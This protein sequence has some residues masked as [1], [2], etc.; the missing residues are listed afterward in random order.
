MLEVA[1]LR[2]ATEPMD[3]GTVDRMVESAVD[4]GAATPA[5]QEVVND[6]KNAGPQSQFFNATVLNF[7]RRGLKIGA[8]SAAGATAA[9]YGS[10]KLAA[11]LVTN[12]ETILSLLTNHPALLDVATRLIA[13]LKQMP[14]AGL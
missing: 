11:W 4:E 14:L 13:I 10:A 3:T 5:A 7:I 2:T 8:V 9:V 1:R 12:A 6:A